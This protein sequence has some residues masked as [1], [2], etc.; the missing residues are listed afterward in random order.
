[1][2]TM[3]GGTLLIALAAVY[4]IAGGQETRG[5]ATGMLRPELGGV[6]GACDVCGMDVYEKMLTR[7][8]IAI[9]DS[10]HHACG[11]GCAAILMRGRSVDAVRIVDFPTGA[12]AGARQSYFVI[13][14]N[15]VPARA[16]V[17]ALA[18]RDKSDAEA[19]VKIHGGRILDFVE[20]ADLGAKIHAERMK[21]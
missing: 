15:A 10:V 9:D 19:F 18:F 7:V 20:M 3:R 4:A 2:R 13:A 12:V 1:M 14:S 6:S 11:F 8:E 5:G 17:P 16:M 21:R